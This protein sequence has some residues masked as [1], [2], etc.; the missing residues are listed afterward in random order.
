M[1]SSHLV[2]RALGLST[3]LTK[4]PDVRELQTSLKAELEHYKIDWLPLNVDGE[5]GPQTLHAA[6]FLTWVI[7][8]GKGHRQSVKKGRLTEA[9][10]RL[11]RNPEKRSAIERTRAKRRQPRL[12]KIRA[13]QAAGPSL[14]VEGA[15]ACIG[16]TE[17]PAGSNTGPD[18]TI[19]VRGK[20]YVVGVSAFERYWG[21]GACFWCLCFA[22]FWVKQ[23]GGRISGNCAYSVAIEG[24]ARN[25]ENGFIQVPVGER[26]AGDLTIWKFAGPS[27]LSDHGEL[28]ASLHEDIGGNT[29]SDSGGSQSNGGGVFSKDV[30]GPARSEA[31]LSMVVRPLYS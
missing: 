26:R 6:R 5:F 3:P 30:P 2:H 14:A 23:A 7:G 31:Q 16:I 8:L 10:Q 20:K 11:L 29:S 17:N 18:R 1:T 4:G 27:A 15:R 24:Y 19:V 13:A 28:V 12:R 25:H 9:T 22:C 21:L